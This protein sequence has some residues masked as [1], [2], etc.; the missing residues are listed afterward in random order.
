[1]FIEYV[2]DKK[3][4]RCIDWGTRTVYESQD[5]I[6]DKGITMGHERVV[7]EVEPSLD[8]E[9]DVTSSPLAITE[10]EDNNLLDLL[11][12]VDEDNEDENPLVVPPLV[13]SSPPQL[14]PCRSTRIHC[15]PVPDD[16]SRYEVTSYASKRKGESA[17]NIQVN[18]ANIQG[19]ELEMY[20]E[21]MSSTD[22]S[23]WKATYAEELISFVMTNL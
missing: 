4:Y 16:D 5:V 13:P 19:K 3:A 8:I 2:A 23:L 11:E 21:T 14:G 22:A 10:D 6:F 17:N 7:V 15:P 18:V 20:E 12:S 1:M 9:Y